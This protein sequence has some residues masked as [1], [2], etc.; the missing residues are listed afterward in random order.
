M[1]IMEEE[2]ESRAACPK[3]FQSEFAAETCLELQ[4]SCL[5]LP[6]TVSVCW[7]WHEKEKP[8]LTSPYTVDPVPSTS[9]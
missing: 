9:R 8:F 7:D 6:L 2:A 4:T 3:P 5:G 1:Y